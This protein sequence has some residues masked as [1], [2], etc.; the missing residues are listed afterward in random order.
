MDRWNFIYGLLKQHGYTTMYSEDQ[1]GAGTF[2]YRLKGFCKQPTDHYTRPFFLANLRETKDQGL[3]CLGSQPSF[4]RRFNYLR[5][6]YKAYPK[7]LKFSFTF[8]CLGHEDFNEL[9]YAE[10]DLFDFIQEYREEGRLNNTMLILFGDHG[11]RYGDIRS[12]VIG[13][14]EERLPFFSITLPPWFKEKHPS[15]VKNLKINTERLTTPYDVHA[16]LKHLLFY[17][18]RPNVDRGRSLFEEIDLSRTCETAKIPEHFCP[19]LEWKPVDIN[20]K[21]I[22][23]SAQAAVR[24]INKL[25]E[26][27]RLSH[28]CEKLQLKVINSAV[29]VEPNKAVQSFSQETRDPKKGW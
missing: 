23:Q 3:H 17:P 5:S 28:K 18:K 29:K 19:C 15:F 2:W 20:H 8:L 12:T 26:D 9:G 10:N 16:M 27:K 21:H 7:V 1:P 22:T 14:L 13:K 6:Y 11:T 24:H 4:R 25:I